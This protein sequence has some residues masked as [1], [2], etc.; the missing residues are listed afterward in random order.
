MIDLL[1]AKYH[2]QIRLQVI[3]ILRDGILLRIYI[4]CWTLLF[5]RKATI[6]F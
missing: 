3:T 4:L 1:K 2:P 5:W 6:A